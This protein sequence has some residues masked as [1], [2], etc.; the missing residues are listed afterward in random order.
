MFSRRASYLKKTLLFNI[1]LYV[2][3]VIILYLLLVFV[4]LRA[5]RSLRNPIDLLSWVVLTLIV[6]MFFSTR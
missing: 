3:D 2:A 6:F 5:V 1:R 4:V